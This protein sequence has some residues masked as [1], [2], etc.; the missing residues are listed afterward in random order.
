MEACA[1]KRR[2]VRRRIGTL[3]FI[4][5]VI[6]QSSL[7]AQVSPPVLTASAAAKPAPAPV[8]QVTD[9]VRLLVGRSTIVDVGKPIAR[10][11]LTSA[12]I[13]D[14]LVT[15]PNELLLN[16]KAAGTISMFVWDRGGAIRRY[17]VVVQRDLARLTAQLKELFPKESIDVRANGKTAVL[18][19]TV[20]SKDVADK[21]ASLAGSFVDTKEELISLLQVGP[22]GRS[23]QVLL[24]VRFAEVSRSAL[25]ELGIGLFTS[26]T[27]IKNTI[28]RITTQQFPS[29]GFDELNYTK[30]AGSAAN[31]GKFGAD[32]ASNSGK[33]TFSDFLNLFLFNEKYDL[34][35]MVKALQTKGLF[36]S[37]AE[38]NLVAESGKEASFLA[39]GEFPIP[40]AQASGG[41][42]SISVIFKEYGIRLSFTPIVNGDRIHLKV[43]PE[44]SSLD[45]SNAV[46]LGGFR[47]PALTT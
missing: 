33:F 13:A 11:S 15:S 2:P 7:Y 44:V 27:G 16:G 14:A 39:G 9:S 10:V 41:G 45:F 12:D 37:L 20:S 3:I 47:I 24:R 19:G 38:P 34:G 5:A 29:V 1:Q 36:Q 28:G 32:V 25:T 35:A 42:T 4:I 43:K 26:P 8:E 30:E 18:S 21:M 23:N 46:V 22:A 31:G 6:G 40:I 17:E